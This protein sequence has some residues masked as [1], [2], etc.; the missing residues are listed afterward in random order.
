M[1][2][3]QRQEGVSI[4]IPCMEPRFLTLLQVKLPL[5]GNVESFKSSCGTLF[6]SGK[7]VLSPFLARTW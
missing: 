1:M 6:F 3:R 2:A 7:E 5:P 4:S